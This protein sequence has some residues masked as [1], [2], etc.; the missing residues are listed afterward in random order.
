MERPT[1]DMSSL[2]AQLGEA[3]DT[4]AIER[5]IELHRPL[6]DAVLLHEATFWS[7]AQSG[8]LFEATLYDSDWASVV[9][10]LNAILHVDGSSGLAEA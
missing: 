3:S 8:F 4:P 1:H 7:P 2:F 9:D 6:G 5:F 10:T